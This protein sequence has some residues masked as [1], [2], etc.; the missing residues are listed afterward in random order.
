MYYIVMNNKIVCD[1]SNV[2]RE[3]DKRR[4]AQNFIDGR[5]LANSIVVEN[6]KGYTEK[7]K[8]TV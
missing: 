4:K 1:S 5:R 7:V 3:F 2:P 6:L 8:V